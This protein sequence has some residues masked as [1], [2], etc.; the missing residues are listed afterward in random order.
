MPFPPTYWE[1]LSQGVMEVSEA[2]TLWTLTR[3]RILANKAIRD[4]GVIFRG[5]EQRLQARY[6]VFITQARGW[7]DNELP[8]AYLRG[9]QK[10]GEVANPRPFRRGLLTP[11]G[12][13][14]PG[15]NARKILSQYPRHL[16]VYGAFQKAVYDDFDQT[17][18]F[19]LRQTRGRIREIN[20]LA[21][22][23]HYREGDIFTRR[24]LTQDLMNRFAREGIEGV[25]YDDGRLMKLDS[26]CEMVART[27]T[28][29]AARQAHLNR[30]QEAGQELV[31]ISSHWPVSPMCEPYQGGV[32]SIEGGNRKYPS[33]QSAMDGGLYHA[34]C[35]HSQSGFTE[36][37]TTKPE[38]E[39]DS[40]ENRQRYD[41]SQKQRYN[42][43]QTRAW[44]R[45]EASAVDPREREKARQ[46]VREWQGKS[47]SHI[48]ENS[49]LRRAYD[50]EQI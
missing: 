28:A 10:G 1:N 17:R 20:I 40:R 45:R 50:R 22:Q 35:Q 15:S 7:A 29:N 5:E 44:K 26:Y 36:G 3:L 13:M 32:F 49:F 6:G 2:F 33:L 19:I 18:T 16:S 23:A 41:A 42:E 39:L 27:Q 9:L 30:L 43:R 21:G 14:P 31:L 11:P 46:K 25:R 47:R 12:G 38:E 24:V 4:P 8:K 48:N 34:N 37:V